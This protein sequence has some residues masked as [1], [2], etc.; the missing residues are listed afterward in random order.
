MRQ[1]GLQMRIRKRQ[2]FREVR[3]AIKASNA[4]IFYMLTCTYEHVS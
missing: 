4:V 1:A 2:R 3:F